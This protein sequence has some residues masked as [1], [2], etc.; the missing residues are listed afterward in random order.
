MRSATAS[1]CDEIDPPVQKRA[2]RELAGLGEP[3]AGVHRRCTI[4]SKHHRAAMRAQLDDV[5]ARVG[6]R[7]GK[8]RGDDLIDRRRRRPR[9]G[10]QR[11]PS[12]TSRAAAASA[13]RCVIERDAIDMRVGAADPHDADAAASRRRRD[14]DDGVGGGEHARP[15]TGPPVATCAAEMRTVFENASPMLS[16]VD[17]GNL[18]D[19]HV[20]DA[21][22]VGIQ[23]TELL[24][25]AA[26][27]RL[28]GQELRHLPQL[29]VLALAVVERVDEDALV[30]VERRGRTPCRRRAA[31]P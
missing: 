27:L 19:G 18:G 14:R 23:R 15:R 21:A 2:Q 25:D 7:R 17:A 13:P 30:A 1:A 12:R 10:L 20:H 28:L 29:D 9:S 6:M 5:F 24:I 11:G 22:L 16:V 8:I 3:R 4:A 26:L 31:A